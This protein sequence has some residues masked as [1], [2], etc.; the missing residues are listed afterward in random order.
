MKRPHVRVTDHAVL[1]YLERVGG[2]DV[3]RLRLEIA[4]KTEEA[5]I[6]GACGVT[7]NGY[8]YR[9]AHG[10]AGPVVTTVM[11]AGWSPERRIAESGK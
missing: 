11:P 9:I 3:D 10:L 8:S 6:A 5:D 4:G 7:I 2:I 1:R